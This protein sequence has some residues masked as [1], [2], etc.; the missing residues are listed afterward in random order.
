MKRSLVSFIATLVCT[1]AVS[2]YSKTIT[3][4]TTNNISPGAG[5]TNLVQAIGLLED[6]DTISFNIPGTG[7][8]YLITPDL[9]NGYPSITKNNVLIDGYSQPGSSPNTN[10]ILGTNSAKIQI[11]L[12]SR[13]G[14]ARVEDIPGYG[15]TESAV[16]FVLGSS[17][18]NIRGFCFLGPG[19][20]GDDDPT[21]PARYAVSMNPGTTA[22][23]V[24]GCWFGVDLDGKTVYR[25]T[26]AVTGFRSDPDYVNDTVIG[27]AKDAAD[28]AAARAQF[29]VIVGEFIPLIIE[30]VRTRISGN[31]LNVFPN[32]NSDFLSDGSEGHELESMIEIGRG[33]DDLVI[34]TD[35]DGKND[36]EERNIFGGVI[37]SDDDNIIEFYGG[38]RTNMVIA[39]NYFGMGVDGVTRFTNSMAVVDNFNGTTT[40]RMGSDFDGVSDALEGN[41]IAM[42]Y[43]F[44][45]LYP[46]PV[47]A[48]VPRFVDIDPGAIVSLRGNRLIGNN[49]PPFSYADGAGDRLE[50]LTNIYAPYTMTNQII[51]TLS[52]NSTATL[53]VGSCDLGAD[54]Y[55]NIVID[56]YL[57]DPEGW[58]NGQAF[59]FVEL[60]Y[61]NSLGQEAFYGFAQGKTYL[62]SFRDNGPQDRNKTA[63]QFELE[64]AS[65][66]L[67]TDQPITVTANYMAEA[68]GTHNAAVITSPFAQPITFQ[69]PS[70]VTVTATKSATGIV[71]SW[72]VSAG[73]F[74][75]QSRSSFTSGAWADMDPQPAITQAG[76]SF[77]AEIPANTGGLFFRLAR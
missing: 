71:L 10:S 36:A 28:A 11:V 54:P 2:G 33:G 20:G 9:P 25:F 52:T 15:T 30:G 31:F 49:I 68:Q 44:S 43:P 24:N 69:V 65:L 32:G 75:I 29:N 59:Q 1:C 22:V 13:T 57:A 35:G 23:H 17:N 46:S 18:V 39:G 8:F 58:V 21:N 73:M 76:G 37:S 40:V 26:D 12:D 53:L 48:T 19:V 42:N 3:V 16:L 14:G 61:T 60:K 74:K 4:T 34:G 50:A 6:G 72:P 66:Q 64:V 70:G 47:G 55:T 56:V 38:T 67:P 63:G 77:Q 5:E 7:P 51:P 45:I 62:G 27:V 41:V